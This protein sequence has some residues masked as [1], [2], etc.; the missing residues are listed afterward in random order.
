MKKE[1]I[2]DIFPMNDIQRGMVLLSLMNPE[3]AI[4][5]DQFVYFVP[6]IDRKDDF[7]QA[8]RL[9][10]KKHPILRTGFDLDNF[11]DEVQIV[12][13]EVEPNVEFQDLMGLKQEEQE[14]RIQE[15]MEKERF[16]IY[17]FKKPPLWCI[18]IFNL[19]DKNSAFL[20]QFHHAVMDGYSLASLNAQIFNTYIELKDNK[21]YKPEPLKAFFKDLVIEEIAEKNNEGSIKYWKEKLKDFNRID[22]FHKD[23]PLSQNSRIG[24]GLEKS[25]EI[26]D[27]AVKKGV[28]H[29]SIVF[30]AFVYVLNMLTLEDDFVVGV[31]SN[32]RPPIED[33]DKVIGCFLNTLPLRLNF[34]ELNKLT[35]MEYFSYIEDQMLELKTRD[36]S[37]L[38]QITKV[39][40]QRD[41][42]ENPYFDVLFNQID[43]V[44]VY[45]NMY[46]ID[47][48]ADKTS[49]DQLQ[50]KKRLSIK[51][52]EM[53]NTY[54][55]I[56][57]ITNSKGELMMEYSLMRALKTGLSIETFH[58]YVM[59]VLDCFLYENNKKT[60]INK[61]I[62]KEEQA[63]LLKEFNQTEEISKFS[64]VVQMFEAQLAKSPNTEILICNNKSYSYEALDRLT[65]QLANYLTRNHKIKKSDL[66][67]IMQGRSEWI[68]ISILAIWKCGAAYLPIDAAYPESRIK[69]M[70]ENSDCSL[71]IDEEII[72][73]F[74][75]DADAYSDQFKNKKLKE[76]DQAY[77]IYTSGSTGNPKGV[78]INH[79]A[80]ANFILGMTNALDLDQSDHLLSL[81]SISFDISI[82][83]LFWT[84]CRGVKTTIK[85]DNSEFFGFDELVNTD[86]KMD[87]SLFYFSSQVADEDDKYKLLMDSA[88]FGDENNFSAV[89]LPERHFHE[90]GGIYPNPSVVGASI[91]AITKNIDIRSGSVVLPLHDSVRVAEEWSVVDNISK[92]RVGLSIASGWHANDF[93]FKPEKFMKRHAIMYE[94]IEELKSLWKGNSIKRIN[95]T[96]KEV[97]IKVYPKP[98][99][100]DLPIWITSAGSQQ[101]FISAG[102]IG[103]SILT[104]MLGQNIN[105][106]ENNI[107]AYKEELVKSGH[108]LEKANVTL[109]LHTYVGADLQEVKEIV[110]EPF[111]GYLR[112]SA[113]LLR[114]LLRGVGVENSSIEEQEME[115][116]LEMVFERYWNT[117]AL[118]GTV[119]SCKKMIRK[120][121]KIGITEIGCLID[122]GIDKKEVMNG[123]EYLNSLKNVIQ[124]VQKISDPITSIQ[125]TP[126]YLNAL[127]EDN[128]SQEFLK[129]LKTIV[130]GGELFAQH[131]KRKV[132]DQT[133]AT[134]YNMYGP[135]ET[136][137]WSSFTKVDSA[138]DNSIGKPIRNT[139]MYVL[140][141]E[142]ELCPIGVKGYLHIGGDGLSTGYYKQEE[143]TDKK[144]IQSPFNAKEKIY[145]TGDLARW[146]PDGTLEFFG[147]EDNQIKIRGHRIELGEIEHHLLKKDDIDA[148]G[149]VINES[150]SG[151]QEL[152]AYYTSKEKQDKSE[153]RAFLLES[154]PP[155]MVPTFFVQLD[156]IPLTSNGKLNKK[157]LLSLDQSKLNA[158]TD[159]NYVKPRNETEKSVLNI[160]EQILGNDRIGIHDKFF[161]IGGNSLNI[162][163]LKRMLKKDLGVSISIVDLF[164]YTTIE[165]LALKINDEISSS[166]EVKETVEV[167]RF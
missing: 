97:D 41:G 156:E 121:Y 23:K 130:V 2:E 43:F 128:E 64:S 91:A 5:H 147:R 63:K 154:L 77:M 114:N 112:S 133:N 99:Q 151:N 75:K 105:D 125:I 85:Q 20:I 96:G 138:D 16:Q 111:K 152:V 81:T 120:L 155:I 109:M 60:N 66:V 51:N 89:W 122:F 118:F 47:K 42:L 106:L 8:L 92:G 83:E 18:T 141:K 157:A 93:I 46:S 110:K 71:I 137:I 9:M 95:G 88:R 158:G 87:F 26:K 108:G 7:I 74:N 160:W 129:S 102:K 72:D 22:I 101:T 59:N 14:K 145:N 161:E 115:D 54:F 17:D 10:M 124:G 163:R 126:S 67:G 55:D 164:K 127:L 84:L 139:Q 21:D 165:D 25:K 103:A 162:I 146:L 79:A 61:V 34:K 4:Y 148:V 27:K 52:H 149:V 132:L 12:Y 135:T 142:N 136:T 150:S 117:S 40:G 78:M 37:T 11:S 82:L 166:S 76:N 1:N 134:I 62:S 94:Q 48:S 116:L 69:Y 140:T 86:T 57:F 6:V 98:I 113:G 13:K 32:N 159:T 24:F 3:S 153:L 58:E 53:T 107:K 39:T 19:S 33:G 44:N 100:N 15:F 167:M 65:N 45:K 131:I 50:G 56:N 80:L 104:H 68:V 144:F 70:R 38:L 123:L 73:L 30:G 36:R 90:F 35:W 31:V 28:S 143:L 49:Q 29:K 119:E